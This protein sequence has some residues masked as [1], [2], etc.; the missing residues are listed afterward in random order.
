[1]LGFGGHFLTKARRYS[2]T[3]TALRQ[4]RVT[5]RRHQDAGPEHRPLDT[6]DDDA[7]TTLVLNWL[8]YSGT[9]WH[10]MADAFLA[11]LPP[12]RPANAAR[13]DTTNSPTSTGRVLPGRLHR[14][15]D[16]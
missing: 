9:G 3:L 12:T 10:T 6:G 14:R 16:T 2:V 1:M 4:A 5:Y 8:T 11:T 13:P 7:E 15:H